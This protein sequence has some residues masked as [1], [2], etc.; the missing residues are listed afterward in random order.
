MPIYP[1]TTSN[2][3]LFAPSVGEVLLMAFARLQIE[4]TAITVQH[5]QHARNEANLL[6]VEWSNSGPNLWTV[7]LQTIQ[8]TQGVCTYPVDP[9]TVMILDCYVSLN[10]SDFSPNWNNPDFN[11][12]AGPRTDLI[13]TPMS[14]S[15]YAAMPIKTQQERPTGFWFDRLI[16]PTIT[17]WPVP[18]QDYQCGFYRFRQVQDVNPANVGLPEVTY[19]A[20]DALVAGMAYRL[21]RIY[22]PA[23]EAMRK[24]D[25][26]EAWGIFADQ[27]TENA[28]LYITPGLNSYYRI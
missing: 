19:L 11:T 6:Q 4:P 24:A 21:S 5:I 8:L 14:R 10:S 13:I 22:A 1:Q 26:K 16:S 23:L 28:D 18:D 25:Y 7:D 17:F 3:Y 15:E 2:T 27:N 20:L 9:A 12:T